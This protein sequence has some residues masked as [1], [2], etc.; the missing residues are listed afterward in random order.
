MNLSFNTKSHKWNSLIEKCEPSLWSDYQ[1]QEMNNPGNR[2]KLPSQMKDIRILD[3]TDTNNKMYI[4][5]KTKN[6]FT[7]GIWEKLNWFGLIN[8]EEIWF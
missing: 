6:M 3:E 5:N 2:M 1:N 8:I 4:S 7:C